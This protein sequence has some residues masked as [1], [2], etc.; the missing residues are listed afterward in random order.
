MNIKE[1][2][3]RAFAAQIKSGISDL[4]YYVITNSSFVSGTCKPGNIGMMSE[5]YEVHPEYLINDVV[6]IVRL[7]Q[8][9]EV[10]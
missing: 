2:M 10:A 8:I 1:N 4:S 3:E 6:R 9:K 5:T 7:Q